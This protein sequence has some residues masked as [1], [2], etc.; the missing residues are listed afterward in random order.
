MDSDSL[1]TIATSL[2]GCGRRP[3][4]APRDVDPQLGEV[5][6]VG[7]TEIQRE[8]SPTDLDEPIIFGR[9]LLKRL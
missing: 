3:R 8:L 7:E 2:Q 6:I 5:S 4:N 1:L 9:E